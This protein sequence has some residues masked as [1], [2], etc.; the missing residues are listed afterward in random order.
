MTASTRKPTACDDAK[1]EREVRAGRKFSVSEAIGRAAGG[2]LKGASPVTRKR[3]AEV[4]I[5]SILERHLRDTEG[6]LAIVLLR[7]VSSSE[8]LLGS[9]DDA[10]AALRRF[11]E[12]ILGSEERLRQFVISV[13]AMWGRTYVEQPHF[14][15]EGQPPDADDPY[16]LEG[17]RDKLADLLKRLQDSRGGP[18]RE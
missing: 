17:V 1:L 15:R 16:T 14:E 5:E 13:D 7:Q 12:G 18:S 11:V 6:A 4:E 2:L 9:Y 3:Q 10:T 8:A